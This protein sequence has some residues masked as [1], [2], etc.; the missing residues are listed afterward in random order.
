MI[1]I[2]SAAKNTSHLDGEGY[3]LAWDSALGSRPYAAGHGDQVHKVNWKKDS[4]YV[5]PNAYFHQH[6]NTGPGPA[7]HIAV[8]GERLPLGFR[9]VITDD[10]PQN[11]RPQSEGGTLIEYEDEDPRVRADFEAIL[12]SNGIECKMPPVTYRN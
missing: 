12:R 1:T 2:H 11:M 3:V 8:Y 7:K 6:L 10:G 5:P 9:P 4:I